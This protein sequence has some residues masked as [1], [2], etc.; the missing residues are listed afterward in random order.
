[1]LKSHLEL[2]ETYAAAGKIN[3]DRLFSA[4]RITRGT[5]RS[6]GG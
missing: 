1:M 3:H 5:L 6:L 4:V 2:R